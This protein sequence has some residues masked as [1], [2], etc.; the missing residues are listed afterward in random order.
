MTIWPGGKR[1]SSE[2]SDVLMGLVPYEQASK[3]A[4]SV[5]RKHIYDGA[6]SIL[7]LA[8]KEA[9]RNALSKIP[10]SVRPLVEAEALRIHAYRRAQT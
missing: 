7:K 6:V 5:C 4:Q 2:V 8:D 1:P 10:V 9:R 3:T